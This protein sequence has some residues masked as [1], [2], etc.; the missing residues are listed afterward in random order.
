MVHRCPSRAQNRAAGSGKRRRT[1]R[2]RYVVDAEA[3]GR[4]AT[5]LDRGRSVEA[6]LQAGRPR[7]NHH[8]PRLR[9]RHGHRSDLGRRRWTDARTNAGVGVRPSGRA[10]SSDS[11]ALSRALRLDAGASLANLGPLADFGH[12]DIPPG[13]TRRPLLCLD[14]D[15]DHC[16]AVGRLGS[17]ESLL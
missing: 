3:D 5:Q 13:A 14:V 4:A 8:L 17:C 1:G 15:N 9:S 2:G 11:D 10:R 16:G 12:P 6:T 7:R